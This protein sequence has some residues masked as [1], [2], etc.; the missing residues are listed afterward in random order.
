METPKKPSDTA[1]GTRWQELA[2]KHLKSPATMIVTPEELDE[3]RDTCMNRYIASVSDDGILAKGR[4]AKYSGTTLVKSDGTPWVWNPVH[5]VCPAC[6]QT[7]CVCGPSD[8]KE[9]IKLTT[10][11]KVWDEFL[12]VSV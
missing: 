3:L 4:V 2:A 8:C 1:V 6:N 5:E 12:S 7:K 9:Q 10:L 11:I